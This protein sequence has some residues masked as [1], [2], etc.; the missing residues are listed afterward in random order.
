MEFLREP[1]KFR[2]L[3]AKLPSGLCNYSVHTNSIH[4]LIILYIGLLWNQFISLG[5]NF[6]EFR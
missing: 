4:V 2:A 1:E 3:G 6:R 5:T